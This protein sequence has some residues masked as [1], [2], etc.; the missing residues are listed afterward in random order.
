M[1]YIAL[2]LEW[3]QPYC[4]EKAITSP[5]FLRGEIVQIGAA[6]MDEEFNIIDTFKVM[7]M[8]K[9]YKKMHSRVKRLTQIKTSDLQKGFPFERAMEYFRTWC[10]GECVFLTWGSDD[11]TVFSENLQMHG[12]DSS[13]LPKWY[14]IQPIFDYQITKEGRQY[15]LSYAMEKV[16]EPPFQAHDA[17]ND[18]KSTA[19]IC[20]HL[21]MQAGFESYSEIKSG[22]HRQSTVK[23]YKSWQ[24]AEADAEVSDFPCEKCGKA[25]HCE[26]WVPQKIDKHIA[27]AECEC[28]EKY[29][30]R[31]RSRRNRDRTI[32]VSRGV[33]PADEKILAYFREKAAVTVKRKRSRKK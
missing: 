1:Q 10:E 8:P 9:Y 22:A 17:L 33:T 31:L 25:V 5:V 16:G 24:E 6:K 2:D 28:G 12:L 15:S 32:R 29:M 18:A 3:N 26:K 21:D 30:V 11:E 27:L 7:V 14:D 19:Q 23:S 20:R 13:W 4:R